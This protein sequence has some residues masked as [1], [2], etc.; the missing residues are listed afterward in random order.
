[1]ILLINSTD[2]NSDIRKENIS[3]TQKDSDSSTANLTASIYEKPIPGSTLR[4]LDDPSFEPN[5]NSPAAKTNTAATESF[6]KA[7]DRF[8]R[9]WSGNSTSNNQ[10][11]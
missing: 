5:I 6:D 8:D 9:F 11:P 2:F 1:M 3:T 4:C 7:H 10:Q